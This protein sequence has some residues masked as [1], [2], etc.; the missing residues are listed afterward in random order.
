MFDVLRP[1]LHH[2]LALRQILGAVVGTAHFILLRV[3][4][5]ALDRVGAESHFVEAHA[6]HH[7]EPVPGHLACTPSCTGQKAWC[8]SDGFV[9][10]SAGKYEAT[11]A[12][13]FAQL[14]ESR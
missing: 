8:F 3:C 5:L 11:A 7:A 14:V 2:L 4:E 6:G 12:A 1:S 13:D 9:A 10:V